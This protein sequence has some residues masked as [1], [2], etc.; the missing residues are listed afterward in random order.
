M[1]SAV[2]SQLFLEA[3]KPQQSPMAADPAKRELGKKEPLG[4]ALCAPKAVSNILFLGNS[5]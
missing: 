4:F 2:V 1:R 5:T 3:L